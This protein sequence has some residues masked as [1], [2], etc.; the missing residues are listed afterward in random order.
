MTSFIHIVVIIAI[1]VHHRCHLIHATS[2]CLILIRL[3]TTS[4]SSPSPCTIVAHCHR[5]AIIW[6]TTT[7]SSSSPLLCHHPSS[8]RRQ[9]HHHRHRHAIIHNFIIHQSNESSII[10]AENARNY[11]ATAYCLWT[12]EYLGRNIICYEYYVYWASGGDSCSDVSL[13]CQADPWFIVNDQVGV[14]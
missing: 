8:G 4:S 5:R 11:A 14:Y 3:P 9:L 10:G 12:C 6:P 2:L 1:A 13:M 7:P